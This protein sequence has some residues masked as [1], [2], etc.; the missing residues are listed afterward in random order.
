[1]EEEAG[2]AVVGPEAR[3]PEGGVCE[4]AVGWRVKCHTRFGVEI[5]CA[6]LDWRVSVEVPR[7]VRP[8]G[9]RIVLPVGHV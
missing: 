9:V 8:A 7:L 3:E 6:N 2:G 4:E 5:F 1:M